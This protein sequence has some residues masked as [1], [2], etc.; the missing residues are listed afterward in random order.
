MC[1]LI[2]T[3]LFYFIEMSFWYL[4]FSQKL[5]EK[6]RLYYNGTSSWI[7]FV[8]F[9]GELKTPKR[10]FEINWPLGDYRI[11]W[12]MPIPHSVGCDPQL[13][14]RVFYVH[15]Q[16]GILS[17]INW[18]HKSIFILSGYQSQCFFQLSEETGA[19]MVGLHF[20]IH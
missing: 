1:F 20:Q 6:I 14:T 5:N 7:V 15:I 12:R 11:W 18:G 17:D 3:Y 9:L 10:H 13:C 4:Q 16:A 2:F 19:T 8:H